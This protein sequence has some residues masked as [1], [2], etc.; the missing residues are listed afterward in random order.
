MV[1]AETGRIRVE[2]AYALPGAQALVALE[3]PAGTTVG[4]A[5][6]RSG[7]AQRFAIGAG[8]VGI[9][10]RVVSAATALQDGD[11][12]EIYRPLIAE[13]KAARRQRAARK[14]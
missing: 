3:V 9:F 6:A 4:E 5:I 11:R 8:K 2:V 13:P 10:G 7:V 14:R 12:V 1:P